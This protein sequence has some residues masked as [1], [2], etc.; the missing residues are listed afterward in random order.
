M[1]ESKGDGAVHPWLPFL[2]T[3]AVHK[4]LDEVRLMTPEQR[5]R[6]AARVVDTVAGNGDW[7]LR[8]EPVRAGK[9]GHEEFVSAWAATVRGLAL[10]AML[11]GGVTFMGMRFDVTQIPAA[12][13]LEPV[14]PAGDEMVAA[15]TARLVELW[16]FSLRMPDRKP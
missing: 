11:P 14:E 15:V 5:Q 13:Q 2:L 1:T 7:L 9:R 10:A 8:W 3:V 12:D 4:D 6:Q 16:D